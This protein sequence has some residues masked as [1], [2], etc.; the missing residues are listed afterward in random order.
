M[1]ARMR[2]I[3]CWRIPAWPISR[4][5]RGV[6]RWVGEPV[7]AHPCGMDCGIWSVESASLCVHLSRRDCLLVLLAMASHR[8]V[9]GLVC[10]LRRVARD[11]VV[12]TC[13]R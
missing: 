6:P 13:E 11:K 8:G 1:A 4:A 2:W 9:K 3:D 12:C 10:L 7:C 5:T